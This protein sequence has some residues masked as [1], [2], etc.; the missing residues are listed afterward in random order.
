MM[1]VLKKDVEFGNVVKSRL[2][3]RCPVERRA[4]ALVSVNSTVCALV[5]MVLE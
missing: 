1:R 2:Q 3:L 4:L 5:S